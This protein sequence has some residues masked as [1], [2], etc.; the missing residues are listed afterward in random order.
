VIDLL[1]ELN[2]K[3]QTIIMVT[4]EE[5]YGMETDRIV[6]LSDGMIDKE[7]ILKK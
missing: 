3:G 5:E 1:K 7:T 2:K 6:H 4:H